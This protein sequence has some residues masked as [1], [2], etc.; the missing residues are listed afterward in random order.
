MKLMEL[1]EEGNISSNYYQN[2]LEKV[3]FDGEYP[4]NFKFIF[5]GKATNNMNLNKTSAIVLIKWLKSI[6]DRLPED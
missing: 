5:N 1:L 6:H 4:A 3:Q 2:Q